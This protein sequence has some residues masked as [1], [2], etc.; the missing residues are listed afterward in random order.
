MA[1]G[2][3]QIKKIHA[4]WSEIHAEHANMVTVQHLRDQASRQKQLGEED[5]MLRDETSKASPD[6]TTPLA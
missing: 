1:N 6:D 5:S 4:L 3:K 2:R